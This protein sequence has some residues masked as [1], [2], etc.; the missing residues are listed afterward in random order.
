MDMPEVTN[1][2]NW[3]PFWHLNAR[4]FFYAILTNQ[5]KGEQRG[6][7]MDKEL[8]SLNFWGGIRPASEMVEDLLA[9]A[10]QSTCTSDYLFFYYKKKSTHFSSLKTSAE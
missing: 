9:Q 8:E 7:S 4:R 5:L 10:F 1:L 2:V 3:V 6:K